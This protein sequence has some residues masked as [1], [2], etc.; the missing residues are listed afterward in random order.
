MSYDELIRLYFERSNALQWY[1]SLYVVV[2][3]GLL[4][5]STLRQRRDFLKTLLVS[6]LYCCFAYKNLSA[7]GETMAQ[8]DAALHLIKQYP[9]YPD[10][11]RPPSL[12]PELE[13]SLVAPSYSGTRT[14]HV[15]CDVLAIA[16]LWVME[17]HRRA[18]ERLDPLAPARPPAI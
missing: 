18:D 15:F 5:F 2:I 10:A 17:S 13:L 7:I 9:L 4:A 1:W 6:V 16:A 3:G 12:R 8:R 14:F 11:T